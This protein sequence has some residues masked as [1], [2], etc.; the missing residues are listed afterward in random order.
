MQTYTDPHDPTRLAI[1]VK[2]IH[3]VEGHMP[4]NPPPPLGEYKAELTT[5]VLLD[6]GRVATI[7]HAYGYTD[8]GPKLLPFFLALTKGGRETQAFRSY[9]AA[10]HWLWLDSEARESREYRMASQ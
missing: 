10:R 9:T 1:P 5:E 3:R 4:G 2:A 6:G 8:N 7:G